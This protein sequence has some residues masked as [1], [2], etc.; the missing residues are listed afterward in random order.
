MNSV[1]ETAIEVKSN[2]HQSSARTKTRYRYPL[3]HGNNFELIVDGENFLPRIFDD[4]RNARQFVMVEMYLSASGSVFNQ[5][6]QAVLQARSNNASVYLLFDGFGV[7]G[8]SNK[9]L[10]TLRN[11]GVHL[12]I[13]NPIRMLRFKKN[14]HRTH[15]KILI[16]DGEIAYTGGTGLL[17]VFAYNENFN[18]YWHDVMVRITGNCVADWTNIF[19]KA[20]KTWSKKVELPKLEKKTQQANENS[21]R[22]VL[23]RSARDSEIRRSLIQQIKT[24][25]SR[26]W[27]T[28]PYFVPARKLRQSL[29]AAAKRGVDVR[30]LL[31]GEKTDNP[32]ARYMA[33]RYYAKL[34]RS[35]VKIYEYEPR[36]IHA[37]VFLVDDWTS[38]GS[39]NLDR[40]NLIWNLD[41][42]QEIISSEFA[43]HVAEFFENDFVQSQSFDLIAWKQRSKFQRFK[44]KLWGYAVPIALWFSRNAE[45][46]RL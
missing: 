19:C 18:E 39:S 12:S 15:R 10:Q 27:L 36:F 11:A 4:I 28:A 23:N 44:E 13:Y 46:H 26:V 29:Y 38:I 7:T 16:I 14:L 35:G 37:K 20:W 32:A 45:K 42:N 3:R 6:M 40:W 17:D 33:R 5:F 41:A 31:P 25:Q 2:I 24:A 9:D 21:G 8:V 22:V 30:L 43:N 34:L 1:N